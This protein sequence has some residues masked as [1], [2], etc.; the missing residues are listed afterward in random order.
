MTPVTRRNRFLWNPDVTFYFMWLIYA[1]IPLYFLIRLPLSESWLGLMCLTALVAAYIDSYR[2]HRYLLLNV[3]IQV[4][5]VLVL[6]LVYHPNN[7]LNFYPASTSGLLP[8]KRTI[9]VVLAAMLGGSLLT[10]SS[11][12]VPILGSEMFMLLP[13]AAVVTALPFAIRMAT[14]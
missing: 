2:R 12:G 9:A 14:K 13:I 6:S 4:L 11:H 3:A 5:C 1:A 7:L 10:F 8:H